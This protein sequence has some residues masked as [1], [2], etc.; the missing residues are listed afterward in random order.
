MDMVVNIALGRGSDEQRMMFLMQIL[1]QQ[2]EVIEK[3]GPNNPLVDLQQYRNT[4]AQVIELSGFQDPAQFVKEVDPAAVDAYM[5]QMSQQQKPMDP[6]E[7]LAQVQAKQIEADILIAAAKQELE[8]KK[9][10]ADADFKRDQLMV[11][12]MLKAAEIE[13]K[14]GSQVDMAMI[15]AEVNRQRTEIQEMFSLQAQREQAMLNMNQIPQQ[16]P[17]PQMMPPMPPQMM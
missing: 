17:A 1:A 9:A 10:Q 11:D 5:Q 3:Y 12:A 13:A 4:L 16:A 2:K 6:T 15:N 14:Y 7:M 8:T